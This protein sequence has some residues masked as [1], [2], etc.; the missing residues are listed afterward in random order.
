[1]ENKIGLVLAYKGTNYGALLQAYAT[2][3]IIESFGFSTEIINYKP[4]R[5]NRSLKFDWGLIPFLIQLFKNKCNKK[6]NKIKLDLLH[7][8][9]VSER[10][11]RG[12]EFRK[13]ML[14][15]IHTYEGYT[16]L[17]K[18]ARNFRA[19]LIGS[20]QQWLPGVSFG[21]HLSLRFV[22]QNIRK[23]SYATSLG[24]SFYPKYCY[25]SASQMWKSFD[26]LSV[27]EEEGKNIIQNICGEI[28]VQVV[29]DP[30]YLL[31]KEEWEKHI[32]LKNMSQ[33]KYVLCYF[34]GNSDKQKQ[35][36]ANFAREKQLKCYSIISDESYSNIDLSFCHKT[37]I[38]ASPM[39]FINWIRGAEY[40]ITDSFHG[41]AFSVINQKQ[42]YIFY[43][44]RE[45]AKLSRNSRID[46]ILRMWE[47]ENR[48]ID[49][50][51]NSIND[52]SNIDY[53]NVSK[54]VNKKR[55]YSLEY[56]KKSLTFNNDSDI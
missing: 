6:R 11:L 53:N 52:T 50:S 2:Q 1:M 39:D 27:R 25:H 19:V 45:D 21:N 54:L 20:D 30:T 9:N 49:T 26:F 28:P 23:I 18:A 51:E 42:F 37:I 55:L 41:L 5:F 24:V 15:N 34:L 31:T 16:N 35:L 46:N 29:A 36:A 14:H 4:T 12:N 3:Q 32:P 38:G 40:V 56:L 44:K 33:E 8:Q 13:N 22:P 47:L 10:K 17:Q 48:F 7:I 43:R